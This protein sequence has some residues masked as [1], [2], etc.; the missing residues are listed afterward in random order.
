V[1][2]QVR[3][4]GRGTRPAL[5]R[6]VGILGGTFNP[7]HLG[8]LVCAQEAH[9]Q[10]ELDVVL[11][12]P[13]NVPP[14]KVLE[15]DPG[16]QVRLALAELAVAA[17]DRFEVSALEL[18]REGPSFTVDTLRALSERAPE[19]ELIFIAGG[20]MARSLPAWREP[21][22]VPAPARSAT[23]NVASDRSCSGSC[24]EGRLR[25][26]SPPAMKIS[27]SSGAWSR[28]SRRVSTVNDGPPRASST[29][30]TS[31][32]SSPAT[33][34]SHSASRTSPPG[35]SSSTLCGGTLVGIQ[36]TMSSPSWACAS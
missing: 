25:A 6:R 1:H 8:H 31:K 3:G 18:D 2:V 35:S 9:A 30:D 16:A 36:V 23:A 17:D 34:R 28:S 7:P 21:E 20:D 32:R 29:A 5:T 27:S 24:Q 4:R 11:W 22:Q 33:A 19:D 26:M 15:N 14:H 13:T 12:V 10:L